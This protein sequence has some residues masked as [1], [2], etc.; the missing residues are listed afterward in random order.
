MNTTILKNLTL[1]DLPI[2]WL[3]PG[4]WLPGQPV[5]VQITVQADSEW[6]Q[7]TDTHRKS[8]QSLPN[9]KESH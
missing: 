3:K 4:H 2:S 5:T 7:H 9:R 6:N 8:L 1:A